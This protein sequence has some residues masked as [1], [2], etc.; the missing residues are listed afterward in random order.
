MNYDNNICSFSRSK[1]SSEAARHAQQY[2]SGHG[3]SVN[4]IGDVRGTVNIGH[5]GEGYWKYLL[6]ALI[7]TVPVAI[8]IQKT[9]SI[10]ETGVPWQK[11]ESEAIL[12]YEVGLQNLWG[13][14]ALGLLRGFVRRGDIPENKVQTMAARMDVKAEFDKNRLAS[15]DLSDNFERVLEKWYDQ[16]LHR[17]KATEAQNLLVDVLKMSNCLD[18]IVFN[19]DA[20]MKTHSKES[21]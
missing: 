8:F 9:L 7:V 17:L 5:D 15:V 14:Q 4:M 12:E 11:A 19:I 10:K 13:S 20:A 18:K 1:R 16:R 6:V 2:V 21:Q 3:A